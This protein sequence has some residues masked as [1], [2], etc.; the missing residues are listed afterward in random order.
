MLDAKQE[1]AA[2]QIYESIPQIR[3]P[4]ARRLVELYSADICHN[5][6]GRVLWMHEQGRVKSIAGY[7]IVSARVNWLAKNGDPVNFSIPAPR[8]KGES[9]KNKHTRN[10]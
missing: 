9:G 7:F 6:L 1:A 3:L 2:Q 8:F 5:T 10:I 4:N